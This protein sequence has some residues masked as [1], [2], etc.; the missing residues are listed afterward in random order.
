MAENPGLTDLLTLAGAVPVVVAIIQALVKPFVPNDRLVPHAA[1]LT[2]IALSLAA[3]VALGR[4]A[5]PEIANAV[6]IGLLAG[7]GAVGAYQVQKPAG[8][9]AAKPPSEPPP[10]PRSPEG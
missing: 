7:L 4:T 8:W 10:E 9:L 6:F 3:T 2:G 1:V 5:T